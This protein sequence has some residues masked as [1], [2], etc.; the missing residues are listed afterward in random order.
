[1]KKKDGVPFL[2]KV[3]WGAHRANGIELFDDYFELR[4][5]RKYENGNLCGQI[6]DNLMT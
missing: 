2:I 1:M 6:I 3:S 5:R 4:T